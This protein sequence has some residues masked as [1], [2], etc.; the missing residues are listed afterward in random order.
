MSFRMLNSPHAFLVSEATKCLVTPRRA[1]RESDAEIDLFAWILI[2]F[3]LIRITSIS[4]D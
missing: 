3:F 2:V 4:I 1:Q